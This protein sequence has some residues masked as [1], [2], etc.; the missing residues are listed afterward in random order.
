[1]R[2]LHSAQQNTAVICEENKNAIYARTGLLKAEEIHSAISFAANPRGANQN[3][4]PINASKNRLG[5]SLTVDV[6][7]AFIIDVY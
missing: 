4:K 6:A 5:H 1:V 2:C 3:L 7:R